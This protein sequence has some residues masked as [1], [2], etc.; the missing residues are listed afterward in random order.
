[1]AFRCSNRGLLLAAAALFIGFAASGPARA[2]DDGQQP[3]WKGIGGMLGLTDTDKFEESI[4]YGERP[5]LV[6]PPATDLPAPAAASAMGADWPNDPDVDRVRKEKDARLHRQQRSPSLDKADN[7]G[8][9][10]SPD[11]LHS[12]HAAP[13]SVGAA[14]HCTVNPR[15]CHWI[16]P[17]ILEKL[18][19]KKEESTIVAGQ[20]PDRD[21]LTD[22]P[23][24]YRLP[25]A[26]TNATFEPK[27]RVDNSDPRTAL[28][29][30]PAQ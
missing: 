13:G 1:M 19:L 7:Y 6:L 2:G 29:K 5:R 8:R 27:V 16:R 3:L 10:I 21:W 25:T 4:K 18:G 30:P 14:D 11:L 20:E 9:P 17:D 22:P 15:N 24:G 23:K 26:N 28:F 12:D